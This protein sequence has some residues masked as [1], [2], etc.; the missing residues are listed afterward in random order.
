MNLLFHLTNC[1]VITITYY[2]NWNGLWSTT[3]R[4]RYFVSSRQMYSGGQR[5]TQLTY[6]TKWNGS[7]ETKT[8]KNY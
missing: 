4:L 3:R 7:S 6:V 5:S 1:Y 8:S 2:F